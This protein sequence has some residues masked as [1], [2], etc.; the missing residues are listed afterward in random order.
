MEEPPTNLRTL[1]YSAGP[2]LNFCR[3]GCSCCLCTACQNGVVWAIPGVPSSTC[4]GWGCDSNHIKDWFFKP[5]FADNPP[6]PRSPMAALNKSACRIRRLMDAKVLRCGS[7]R[8]QLSRYNSSAIPTYPS[9]WAGC[10][11]PLLR[12]GY[13]YVGVNKSWA[14]GHRDNQ[15]RTQEFF[16]GGFNK[17][18]WGQRRERMGIWGPEPPTQGFWRQL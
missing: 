17:F 10:T 14:L 15:W 9:F 5:R 3:Y 16:S 11:Q 7:R 13:S 12:L 2:T 1:V 8:L 4:A 18:S 6:S